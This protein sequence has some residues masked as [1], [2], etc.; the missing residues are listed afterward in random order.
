MDH[1]AFTCI[2]IVF[3]VCVAILIH[4]R[5]TRRSKPPR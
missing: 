5:R 3:H 4:S 2:H 1:T